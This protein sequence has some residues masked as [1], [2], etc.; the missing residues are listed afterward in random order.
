M[1]KTN[2]SSDIW[3][4]QRS[5]DS[6]DDQIKQLQEIIENTTS[7]LLKEYAEDNLEI[8]YNYRELLQNELNSCRGNTF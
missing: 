2:R 8:V 1:N 7:K 5:L 3:R 4:I 6:L